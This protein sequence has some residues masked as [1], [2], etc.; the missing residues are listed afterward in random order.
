MAPT[1]FVMRQLAKVFTACEHWGSSPFD[2][3]SWVQHRGTWIASSGKGVISSL[4]G[5]AAVGAL[6]VNALTPQTNGT[7]VNSVTIAGTTYSG[8]GGVFSPDYMTAVANGKPILRFPATSQ[9]YAAT[10]PAALQTAS[11]THSIVVAPV[12]VSG[13]RWVYE[14][15]GASSDFAG[16]TFTNG[17]PSARVGDAVV[18]GS[19]ISGFHVLTMTY[20]ASTRLLTLYVDGVSVGTPATCSYAFVYGSHMSIGDNALS[21]PN[22]SYSGD[23]AE[24]RFYSSVLGPGNRAAVEQALATKW[25]VTY[26]GPSGGPFGTTKAFAR[27]PIGS[28]GIDL[29]VD[30]VRPSISVPTDFAQ[31][32]FVWV[33]PPSDTATGAQTIVFRVYSTNPSGS[34]PASGSL[35]VEWQYVGQSGFTSQ[36]AAVSSQDFPNWREYTVGIGVPAG[37]TLSWL[38]VNYFYGT[39]G[40]WH[41]D[42]LDWHYPVTTTTGGSSSVV[43]AYDPTTDSAYSLDYNGGTTVSLVQHDGATPTTL[44]TATVSAFTTATFGIAYSPTAGTVVVTQGGATIISV[45]L[46]ALPPTTYPTGTNSGIVYDGLDPSQPSGEGLWALT[47]GLPSNTGIIQ[48]NGITFAFV[49]GSVTGHAVWARDAASTGLGVGASVATMRART[50]ANVYI[51]DITAEVGTVQS[52]PLHT[53]AGTWAGLLSDIAGADQWDEFCWSALA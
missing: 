12:S 26:A 17:I 51:A 33:T 11:F 52:N 22:N 36:G 23:L 14:L 42:Q 38:R 48:V 13:T 16:F 2:L 47:N 37:N 25:G 3:P 45:T 28:A 8:G 46:P 1:T 9:L 15:Q 5:P 4:T 44:G 6:D 21:Y 35:S 30:L 43:F 19:A 18:T 32:G 10:A 49:S 39:P 24:L 41:D 50:A 53:M 20:D 27:Y 31:T 29:S 34:V 7:D 40:A